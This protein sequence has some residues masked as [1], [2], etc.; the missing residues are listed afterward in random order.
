MSEIVI[1]ECGRKEAIGVYCPVCKTA[2]NVVT[3]FS[4]A[5][6]VAMHKRGTGHQMVYVKIA[7]AA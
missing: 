1:E 4:L 7:E 3:F 5:Q 6:Q 2:S